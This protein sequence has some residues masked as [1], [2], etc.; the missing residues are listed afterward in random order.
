M[1]KHLAELV[2]QRRKHL[3]MNYRQVSEKAGFSTSFISD[4]EIGLQLKQLRR[5]HGLAKALQ[6]TPI[7]L[8]E[9]AWLDVNDEPL[10]SRGCKRFTPKN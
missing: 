7:T 10:R 2:A 3:G 4:I 9:A 1:S 6:I 8:I 5:L